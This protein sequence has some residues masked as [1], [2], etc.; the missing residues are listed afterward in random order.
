MKKYFKLR[1]VKISH[2]FKISNLI[3]MLDKMRKICIGIETDL[4]FRNE[5]LI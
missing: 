5:K 4:F 3:I 1:I 2:A